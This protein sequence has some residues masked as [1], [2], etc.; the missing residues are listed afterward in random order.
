MIHTFT[1]IEQFL[2]CSGMAQPEVG[3]NLYQF[4][5]QR[6]INVNESRVPNS[7]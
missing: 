2:Y 4:L 6:L 7:V 1:F 5:I 3:E